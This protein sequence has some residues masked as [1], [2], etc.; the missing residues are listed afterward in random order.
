M[1]KLPNRPAIGQVK[2][3]DESELKV[4][5]EGFKRAWLEDDAEAA[6]TEFGD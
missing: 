2:G 1:G 5:Q 6:S 3:N 4:R